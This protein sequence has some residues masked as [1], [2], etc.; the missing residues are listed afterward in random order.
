MKK[1]ILR[2]LTI[3][4]ITAII[5]SGCGGA[6]STLRPPSY[7]QIKVSGELEYSMLSL[8]EPG[9]ARIA[10]SATANVMDGTIMR[11]SIESVMGKQLAYKD[12]IKNGDNLAAEFD[13]AGISEESVY[14][15]L[16]AHPSL[17]GNQPKEVTE[18]YG[19]KF[20]NL[21]SDN[22]QNIIWNNQGVIL[23]F[24]TGQISLK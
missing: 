16:T 1:N 4:L 20:E 23:I 17:Y 9:N 5:L 24:S 21:Y 3:V 11:F 15:F 13:L 12:V 7:S 22:E 10:L 2:S 18:A 8:E 19:K 6:P 14:G